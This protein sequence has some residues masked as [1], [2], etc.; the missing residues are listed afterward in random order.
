MHSQ[1]VG[2]FT[3]SEDDS[4]FSVEESGGSARGRETSFII[5]TMWKFSSMCFGTK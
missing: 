4:G 2:T 3:F 1:D 5:Q